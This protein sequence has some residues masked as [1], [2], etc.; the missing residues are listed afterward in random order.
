MGICRAKRNN[1]LRE[2]LS[3]RLDP[4]GDEEI[5]SLDWPCVTQW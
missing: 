3:F 1:S 2:V 4:S 5:M